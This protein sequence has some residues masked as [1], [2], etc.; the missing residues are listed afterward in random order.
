LA[1]QGEPRTREPASAL[2][3]EAVAARSGNLTYEQAS[4]IGAVAFYLFALGPDTM[5]DGLQMLR[6]LA[7]GD[8]E[9]AAAWAVQTWCERATRRPSERDGA[10]RTRAALVAE[11]ARLGVRWSHLAR[12][13]FTCA[14][15]APP[16]AAGYG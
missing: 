13:A 2:G 8:Q 16:A 10:H 11:F 4:R 3:L 1:R 6:H 15:A 9:D 7:P 12:G 14:P 5:S